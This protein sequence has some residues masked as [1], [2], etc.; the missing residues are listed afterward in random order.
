MKCQEWSHLK[1]LK[2]VISWSFV[3][4]HQIILQ[5]SLRQGQH[6]TSCHIFC[7]LYQPVFHPENHC[8]CILFT[9]TWA[10]VFFLQLHKI[11][12]QSGKIMIRSDNAL[13]KRWSHVCTSLFKCP[14]LEWQE[15]VN[16]SAHQTDASSTLF[17]VHLYFNIYWFHFH[18]FPYF[19]SKH[20]NYKINWTIVIA[21]S[22]CSSC[23][24]FWG[25]TTQLIIVLFN[26]LIV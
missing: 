11:K 13:N 12:L 24:I 23:S 18:S 20:W 2:K 7:Q 19:V 16:C 21:F 9:M 26:S 14:L 10:W 25:A 3:S 8:L 5:W 6:S 1:I 15:H 22:L 17:C 4:I